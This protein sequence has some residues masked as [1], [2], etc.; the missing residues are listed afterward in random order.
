MPYAYMPFDASML[1]KRCVD[2]AQ[3]SIQSSDDL[4]RHYHSSRGKSGSQFKGVVKAAQKGA[5]SG[6][7]KRKTAN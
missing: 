7:R 6:N 1:N 2:A 3:L 4:T 5:H